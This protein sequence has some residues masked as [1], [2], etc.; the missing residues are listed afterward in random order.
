MGGL[1]FNF[2]GPEAKKE[3]ELRQ[4][5]TDLSVRQ[6]Q[7]DPRTMTPEEQGT[8]ADQ[9]YAIYNDPNTSPGRRAVAMQRMGQIGGQVAV[10]GYGNVPAMFSHDDAMRIRQNQ[11][12]TTAQALAYANQK[13]AE[14]QAA[15]NPAL[16]QAYTVA[17][18]D[19]YKSAKDSMKKLPIKEI[20]ELTDY[21]SLVDLGKTANESITSPSL[22]GPYNGRVNPMLAATTGYPD[23]TKMM[24]AFSGVNNQILKARSG[25]AVTDQEAARFQAEIGDPKSNDFPD[26]M[27][28]FTAQRKREYLTKLQVLRDSGYEIPDTLLPDEIREAM[29][30][31]N[32]QFGGAQNAQKNNAPTSRPV[33]QTTIDANGKIVIQK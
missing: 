25:G 7:S 1:N 13:I 16:A 11:F 21:K 29:G 4:R 5:L 3:R 12:E 19:S 27:Q 10:Q 24:Q 30:G 2:E 22:Y 32:K 15:G 20:G 18:D 23:Y 9:E 17:R 33:I 31:A 28:S 6:M 26:R 8:T 14:A